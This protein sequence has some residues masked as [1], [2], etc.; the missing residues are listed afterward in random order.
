MSDHLAWQAVDGR[1]HVDFLPF[2]RNETALGCAIAN[3]A[4]VQ[5]ALGRE[6]LVENPSLYVDL[7]GHEMSEAE[8]LS[9]LA[10]RTGCGLLL[11][12]NNLYVSA[13]NLG[14]KAETALAALPIRAVAEIHLAGHGRDAAPFSPLLIDTHA[15]PV[16]EAVWAL[17]ASFIA[18]AGPRPTL[19]E[20]DDAVPAFDVLMDERLR[21]HDLLVEASIVHV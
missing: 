21:A 1:R 5:D 17:Y 7:P 4:R 10:S 20:R 9:E 19:I 14:F 16:A 11:D 2:P 12:L 6:I 13:S 8:F 15:A 18:G 3:V